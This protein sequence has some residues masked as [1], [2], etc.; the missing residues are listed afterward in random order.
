[1]NR[2]KS[3]NDK[4]FSSRSSSDVPSP[5][6]FF[7]HPCHSQAN[8]H[9]A[10][11]DLPTYSNPFRDKYIPTKSNPSK[12]KM[13]STMTTIHLGALGD[14]SVVS[15]LLLRSPIKKAKVR[16]DTGVF[17]AKTLN[18]DELWF[19]VDDAIPYIAHR[20]R[21]RGSSRHQRRTTQV[22]DHWHQDDTHVQ[23]E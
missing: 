1:M 16:T 8:L 22:A 17:F 13:P 20:R 21:K 11:E 5:P 6:D 10:R 23:R 12:P 4:R 18:D 15:M 19:S 9:S 3:G 7:L 14:A 2:L